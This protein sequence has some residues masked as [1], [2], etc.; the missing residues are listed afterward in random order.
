MAKITGEGFDKH[1]ET[2]G[3]LRGLALRVSSVSTGIHGD[4]GLKHSRR[5]VNSVARIEM[6]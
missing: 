6:E 5:I 3:F 1:D 2:S 4:A